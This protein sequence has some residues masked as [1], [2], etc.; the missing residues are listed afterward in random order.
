MTNRR[1]LLSLACVCPFSLSAFG[2]V[3][4]TDRSAPLPL[5]GE[6]QSDHDLDARGDR[7]IEL[8]GSVRPPPGAS[9][10]GIR[11]WTPAGGEGLTDASGRYRFEVRLPA[12]AESVAVLAG[13]A[14]AA[15]GSLQ[16]PLPAGASPLSLPEIQLLPESLCAPAWQPTFGAESGLGFGFGPQDM[17][18]FDDGTGASLY[19]AGSFLSAGGLPASNLA[20]YGSQGWFSFGDTVDGTLYALADFDDGS[21]SALYVAGIIG[22]AGGVPVTNV[23][24]FDG[25]TWSALGAGTNG[26]ILDLEVFDDGSGPALYAAGV[27]TQAGGAPRPGVA[28]WDGVAWSSLGAGING[29]VV[30]LEVADLG[31]GPRLYAGGSFNQAG[32]IPAQNIA[33]WDGQAWSALGAGASGRVAALEEI[34]LGSG[35]RLYVGGVFASAGGQPTSNLASFDGTGWS[36]V[37]AGPTGGFNTGVESLKAH[38]DG[39]GL[40]LFITGGFGEAGGQ[41]AGGMVRFDGSTWTSLLPTIP[42]TFSGRQL[43]FHDNGSGP[44][45][46]LGAGFSAF[47]GPGTSGIAAW[48]GQAWTAL[49]T[50]LSGPVQALAEH[51]DGSGLAVYAGGSFISADDA[52]RLRIA[53]FQNGSWSPV[54]PGFNSSVNALL[55]FDDGSGPA[56][57]AGGTFTQAGSQ[58]VAWLARWNGTAWAP[59]GGGLNGP[60]LAVLAFDD[61]TG[62]KLYAGGGFSEAGGIPASRVALWDGTSWSALGAGLLGSVNTLAVHNDGT[63]AALYAGGIFTQSGTVPISRVARWDGS[64]WQPL[65]SGTNNVVRALISYDD[66]SGPALI[67][68][69]SFT[70]AG[71]VPC[72][73]IAAWSGGQWNP[74]GSGLSGIGNALAAIDDG[75]GKQLYVGGGFN[76]AGG[77]A[78][79]SLARWSGGLWSGL[80]PLSGSVNALLPAQSSVASGPALLVGGSFTIPGGDANLG[81]WQGCASGAPSAVA[82]CFGNPATLTTNS[83]WRVGQS[84]NLDFAAG[85]YPQGV[86]SYWVGGDGSDA[87][88]CGMPLPFVGELLLGAPLV[89]L[90]QAPTVA[91]ASGLLVQVPVTPSLIGKQ[92]AIQAANVATVLA[93][94]PVELS[95][96]LVGLIGS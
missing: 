36:P 17:L 51:D 78:V 89:F 74:L 93:A 15:R 75:S 3:S 31:T 66:G 23:A 46:Y 13:V 27:F 32:G 10:A 58:N 16:L 6:L 90:G 91:G 9:P 68:T 69:G 76:L 20:S 24:R 14:G 62:P 94:L 64:L 54:G 38:D 26:L 44:R 34:D 25:S 29:Q 33:A 4:P 88:G 80:D 65:A 19:I 7:L 35:P 43:A 1:L 55:S 5:A 59:V 77:Q 84:F 95:N 22:S 11:V 8:S 79:S 50:G 12:A 52:V 45:L 87:S 42:L 83:A 30:V 39:S 72:A 81:L 53:R 60:V 37:A 28:R 70:S 47:A 63:G 71:G 49:G 57:F 73:R 86:T 21:G 40:A 2:Q 92:V 41:P 96:S 85:L 48:D 82:G 18:S 61:G 67:A 56:L